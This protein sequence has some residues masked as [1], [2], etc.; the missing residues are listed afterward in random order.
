MSEAR[1]FKFLPYTRK[2][3]TFCAAQIK[4]NGLSPKKLEPCLEQ[5]LELIYFPPTLFST[6]KLNGGTVLLFEP[7]KC[8]FD[9]SCY[10]LQTV[11]ETSLYFPS[12]FRFLNPLLLF[13]LL[14]LD[15]G[16]HDN[17]HIE[18]SEYLKW[19]IVATALKMVPGKNQVL[20]SNILK[21]LLHFRIYFVNC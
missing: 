4:L 15:T 21:L 13:P 14:P 18:L 10:F 11:L 7:L 1:P 17:L 12:Y 19:K 3:R 9:I 5:T 16:S 6:Q 8:S 2:E 20:I